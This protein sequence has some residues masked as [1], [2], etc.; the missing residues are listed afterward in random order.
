MASLKETKSRIA[1]VKSTRQITSAMKMVSSA[2]LHKAQA[3]ITS[4]WPYQQKLSTILTNFLGTDA[5]FSSPLAEERPH[6]AR[7]AIMVFS[8]NSS[9]CGAFNANVARLLTTVVEE[10]RA[11]GV[12]E[13]LVYP[14]GKKAEEA[15]K[16]LNITPQGSYQKMAANP[17]FTDAYGF[18]DL[19]SKAFLKKEIDRVELIYHHYKSA[20]SQVL[21]REQFL[22]IDVSK[23]IADAKEKAGQD[24]GTHYNNDYIIEPSVD[25]LIADLLP[26]VLAQKLYTVMADTNASEHAARMI[27]M[28]VATDNADDLIDDLT[29]QYNKGRQQAITSELLDIVGGSTQQ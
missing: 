21:T 7:V 17:T 29:K 28:Q 1:S 20:S 6:P 16:K 18:Y 5:S 2:K 10:Y 3:R 12:E 25:E 8:S 14:V 11:Q 4:M 27:A 19:F 23:V 22:P 26:Q 13:L 15:L 9:L 24:G